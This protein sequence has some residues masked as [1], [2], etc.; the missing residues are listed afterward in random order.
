M[1]H[2]QIP[3]KL[4]KTL[5]CLCGCSKIAKNSSEGAKEA[6]CSYCEL[7][8]RTTTFCLKMKRRNGG[9]NKGIV[10]VVGKRGEDN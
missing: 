7:M 5:A 6:L 3:L 8:Q 2:N 4:V 1:Q 9:R 10:H